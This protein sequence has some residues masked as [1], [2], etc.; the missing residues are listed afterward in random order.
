MFRLKWMRFA[1]LVLAIVVLGLAA[2]SSAGTPIIELPWNSPPPYRIVYFS[3]EGTIPNDSPLAPSRLATILGARTVHNWSE[4]PKLDQS[5]P[6]DALVIH[7]SALPEVDNI[8]LVD[9]YQRGMTVATFNVY[10]P[11]LAE[12]LND[13]CIAA[14][15]FASEPYPDSFYVIAS[16][17][18][19]GQPEDVARIR[20]AN[21]CGEKQ[22]PGIKNWVRERI[23]RSTDSLDKTDDDKRFAIVLVGHLRGIEEDKRDALEKGIPIP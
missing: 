9:T 15:G 8:W 7:N 22:V 17:L 5:A 12:L 13:P 3:M 20:E 1:L 11:E 21:L 19:L 18:I 6:I 10:A 14:D 4:I 16:H 2:R 23:D